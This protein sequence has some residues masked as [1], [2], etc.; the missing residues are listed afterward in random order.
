MIRP[1]NIEKRELLTEL[2]KL[3]KNE[4]NVLFEKNNTVFFERVI[5]NS[6]DI[7]YHIIYLRKIDYNSSDNS[8]KFTFN[9]YDDFNIGIKRTYYNNCYGVLKDDDFKTISNL[10]NNESLEIDVDTLKSIINIIKK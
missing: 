3:V 4:R 6:S 5:P 7:S 2:I 10:T 1:I 9:G 8:I